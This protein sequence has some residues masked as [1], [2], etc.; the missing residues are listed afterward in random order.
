MAAARLVA[1][2][3]RE[4]P[5]PH[6]VLMGDL[7]A[8][9][10]SASVRFRRGQ[11]SLEGVSVCY[12]DAWARVHP[13][14]PGHTFDPG[15]PLVARGDMPEE[16]GRRIDYIMVRCGAYGPTLR[17]AGCERV[18]TGPREGVRA[19]DHYGVPADL[20]PPGHPPGRWA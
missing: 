5:V 11:Q 10:E 18:L 9:P 4:G 16:A 14:R 13:G 12:Q 15:N 19:G 7:D 6:V 2:V 1:E 17:V 3:L 20:V 8:S